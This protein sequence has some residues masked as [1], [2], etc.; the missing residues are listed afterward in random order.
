MLSSWNHVEPASKS[1]DQVAGID[2]LIRQVAEKNP[3]A[4]A[5]VFDGQTMTYGQL[6]ER[7]NRVARLLLKQ[8][9]QLGDPV[10]L[11]VERSSEM[12]IGILAILKA[13]GCYVP[14]DVIYPEI[15]FNTSWK[16]RRF[17]SF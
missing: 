13:G 5:A 17:G 1:T 10:G 2:Q 6:E 7:A 9:V 16:M 3:H 12:L 14:L 4:I 11:C 8:G 15:I